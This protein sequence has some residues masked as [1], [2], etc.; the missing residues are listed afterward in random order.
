MEAYPAKAKKVLTSLSDDS[1]NQDVLTL[2]LLK[3][4]QEEQGN[5]TAIM[6]TPE[7]SRE[8]E[9]FLKVRLD[10]RK[11]LRAV[12]HELKKNIEDLGTRLRILNIGLVPLLIIFISIGTGV[13]RVSRRK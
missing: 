6:L 13:Y 1:E 7:Q 2:D 3:K 11:E 10:I 5:N 12:Q 9:K 8:M 4:L